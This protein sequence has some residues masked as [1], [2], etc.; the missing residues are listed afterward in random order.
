MF[1]VLFLTS[2]QVRLQHLH[3]RAVVGVQS[4]DDCAGGDFGATVFVDLFAAALALP[5]RCQRRVPAA[6]RG[7]RADNGSRAHQPGGLEGSIPA[8]CALA[9]WFHTRVTRCCGALDRSTGCSLHLFV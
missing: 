7:H 9:R 4:V 5:V 8:V 6:D 2:S 3:G 1:V